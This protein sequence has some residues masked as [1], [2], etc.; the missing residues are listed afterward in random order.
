MKR[1]KTIPFVLVL[2]F[3][4]A[5]L[6]SFAD[7]KPAKLIFYETQNITLWSPCAN[8][9]AGEILAGS[10]LVK[11]IL[12]FDNDGMFTHSHAVPQEGVLIGQTT[13]DRYQAN[14]NGG[15]NYDHNP[16]M[17]AYTTTLKNL[18]HFVG[19]GTQVKAFSK[20]HITVNANGDVKVFFD[21]SFMECK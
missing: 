7:Q 15:S 11:I 17:G 21:H 9:G 3:F 4:F 18:L 10:V 14:G 8:E 6:T 20:S 12:H 19:P 2:L 1:L 13:G 16:S 5:T